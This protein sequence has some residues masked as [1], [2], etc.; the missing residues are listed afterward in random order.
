MSVPVYLAI[1]RSYG[2]ILFGL[3]SSLDSWLILPL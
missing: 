1:T 2:T 3:L